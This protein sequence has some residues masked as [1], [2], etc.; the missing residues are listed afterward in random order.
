MTL[1]ASAALAANPEFI[2]RVQVAVVKA[3]RDIIGESF[4]GESEPTEAQHKRRFEWA[5]DALR[6]P[7]HHAE[8]MAW[9]VAAGGVIVAD[10][11]DG[12]IE[13]TVNGLT[14]DYAGVE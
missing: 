5:F 2:S 1:A 3:A 10:S 12:D 11:I 7:R 14:N 9:G 13:W 6:N 8:L 4:G